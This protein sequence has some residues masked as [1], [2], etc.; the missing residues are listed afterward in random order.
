MTK[1]KSGKID[2]NQSDQDQGEARKPFSVKGNPGY[3]EPSEVI[4][5]C[6][7]HQLSCYRDTG[8][9]RD[10][11]NADA[12]AGAGDQEDSEETGRIQI[13]RH[14]GNFNLLVGSDLHV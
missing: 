12:V 8:H 1:V 2:D 9:E 11:K 14:S 5:D 13:P 7:D 10:T 4:D 3:A 6:R